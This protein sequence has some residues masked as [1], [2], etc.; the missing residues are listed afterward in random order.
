MSMRRPLWLRRVAAWTP[1]SE[2]EGGALAKH[3][4]T[5]SS[6]GSIPAIRKKRS[7][8]T[9]RLHSDKS[10][11][12]SALANTRTRAALP[13]IFG[14]RFPFTNGQIKRRRRRERGAYINNTNYNVDGT[15]S[16]FIQKTIF[17]PW[18]YVLIWAL[19]GR[20]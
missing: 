3:C 17:E 11:R 2:K 19:N 6:A 4:E 5:A 16:K 12:R 20:F 8:R 18:F 9:P 10:R 14:K 7:G 1:T 13:A 15:M